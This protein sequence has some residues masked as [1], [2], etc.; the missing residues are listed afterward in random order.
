MI[1]DLHRTMPSELELG[2]CLVGLLDHPKE[3]SAAF[4]GFLFSSQAIL[5]CLT[6]RGCCLTPA[7]SAQFSQLSTTG[8]QGW[9][10]PLLAQPYRNQQTKFRSH[11]TQRLQ[12]P[13]TDS[14]PFPPFIHSTYR[15][16]FGWPIEL[17]KAIHS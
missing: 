5:H 12:V 4:F 7:P 8:I 17:D 14:L 6:C 13:L 16:Q 11:E 15:K 2:V 9:H 10:Y 3:T 1:P